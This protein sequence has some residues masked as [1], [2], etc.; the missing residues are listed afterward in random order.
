MHRR[1]LLGLLAGAVAV[2]GPLWAQ[3]L[4]KYRI[5]LVH[6]SSPVSELNEAHPFYR[7]FFAELRQSAYVEGANLEVL[8]FSGEG[9]TQAYSDLVRQVVAAKPDVGVTNTSRMVVHF[10]EASSRLPIVA[11]TSDP[12]ALGI[13][14]SLARP[15]GMFTGSSADAGPEVYGKRLGLSREAIPKLSTL[16]F[17]ATPAFWG[18]ALGHTVRDAAERMELRLAFGLIESHEEV[19]YRNAFA[20]MAQS[21]VDA[22]LLS[23]QAEHFSHRQLIVDFA[24]NAKLPTMTTFVEIVDVGGLIAYGSD[25]LEQFRYLATCVDKILRGMDPTGIPILLV[26]NFH[27]AINLKTAKSLRLAIPPSL[28]ARADILIE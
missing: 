8:R 23:E 11:I 19:H 26:T 24:Q 10:E 28:L 20:A 21:G 12:V 2:P 13:A 14:A 7:A 6:P 5:A 22:V 4:K 9:H 18:N 15:G 1:E 27:L 16:G 17:I 25:R 3:R